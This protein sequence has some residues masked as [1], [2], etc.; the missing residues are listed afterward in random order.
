MSV[1]STT[2]Q[3][4]L[5]SMLGTS[6]LT[7]IAGSTTGST[8]GSLLSAG[9][10]DVTTLVTQL[11]AVQ[12]AP[13]NRLKSQEQG[14]QTRLSAY[15]QI[16]SALSA[17]QTSASTMSL[18]S[19]FQSASATVTGSGVSASVNGSAAPA[20]Y[21]VSVSAL[22]Q[23][24]AVA[25]TAVSDPAAATATGTLTLQLGSVGNGAFA[26]GAGV[27][28]ISVTIDSTNNSLNGIAA[29]INTA[30]A[31]SVNASVVTDA[32]G[33]RLV[34]NSAATGA[35]SAFTVSGSAGLTQFGFDPSAPAANAAMGQTQAAANASY[36]V[37]GLALTSQSNT[38]TSAI[39]GVTLNLTQAPP[40]GGVL[41]SQI[42][43]G[44]D[45][46]AI[47]SHVNDF[48]ANYNKVV[49]TVNGLTN[50]N[51]QTNTASTLTGDAAARVTMGTLQAISGGAFSG[52]DANHAYLAQVGI[53]V[54][55]DGTLT[56]DSTRFQAAFAANP[57][58]V[59][60]MFT[61]ATGTG[62]QQGFAVQVNNAA[63]QMISATGMLGA[64]EQTLRTQISS[65]TNQIAL[66]QA[67]LAQTQQRLLQE[68]SKV[69]AALSAAQQQQVSI[70]NALAALPG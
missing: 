9:P 64:S 46:S 55:S 16:Q 25:S 66:M 12:S 42:T 4:A 3:A 65:M 37:N 57:G 44:T 41:Q 2:S 59:T 31:G 39:S 23:G 63:Q 36:S 26:A 27:A 67:S 5:A 69:N 1:A 45:S 11:M 8:T 35:S 40:P 15:G 54:N 28:P 53:G 19:S 61:T 34:L 24:Q 17:L 47:T 68:Y 32:S 43:V 6:T 38:I 7:S 56:L 52:S 14:V 13:V 49:T 50:Y 29:A 70:A 62:S 58:A 60:A 33:S 48:I 22:A 51:A 21:S 20:N 30:A 18:A 10:L